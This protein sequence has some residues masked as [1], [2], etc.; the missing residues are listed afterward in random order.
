MT[1]SA[2]ARFCAASTASNERLENFNARKLVA[3]LDEIAAHL[4]AGHP[5]IVSSAVV[6]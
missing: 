6:R 1:T 2:A 4:D 5:A 3:Q